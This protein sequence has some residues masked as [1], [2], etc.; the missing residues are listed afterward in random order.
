MRVHRPDEFQHVTPGFSIGDGII[1]LNELLCFRLIKRG[2]QHSFR[3]A[4]G[5]TLKRFTVLGNPL[6]F[7]HARLGVAVYTIKKESQ[8]HI[9]CTSNVIKARSPYAVGAT[10]IFLNLLEGNANEFAQLFLRKP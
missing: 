6:F 7:E 3:T 1:S 5:G 10:F 2:V 4:C 9:K 8:G